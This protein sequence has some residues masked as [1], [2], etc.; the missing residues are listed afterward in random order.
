MAKDTF[1]FSHDYH[2]RNDPRLVC[3]LMN[4]GVSGIGVYWCLVEMLYEQDGYIL[5]SDCERIAFELRIENDLV[6]SIIS[7]NLFG[8]DEKRFWSES[9]L[10]RL[11]IRKNKSEKARESAI[12]RWEHTNAMRPHI[13]GN[14]IKERKG[15][16]E[17]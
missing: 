7:S 14:A 4:H 9:A 3:L 11:N 12:S 15:N 13:N 2:S 10:K 1:Y 17:Y 6:Q 5:L 16:T 8:K